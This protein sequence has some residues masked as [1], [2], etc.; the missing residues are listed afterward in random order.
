MISTCAQTRLVGVLLCV[1]ALQRVAALTQLPPSEQTAR[2]TELILQYAKLLAAKQATSAN[3]FLL[4]CCLPVRTLI[5]RVRCLSAAA[6][7]ED[8]SLFLYVVLRVSPLNMVTG[9]PPLG[10][11]SRFCREATACASHRQHEPATC[12][13]GSFVPLKDFARQEPLHPMA[14]WC[15]HR[16][17]SLRWGSDRD[18]Q[19]GHLH[20]QQCSNGRSCLPSERSADGND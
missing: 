6:D 15:W 20:K 1:E 5:C 14:I 12:K 4:S 11:R 7:T 17:S 16:N 10:S 3:S 9:L 13:R 2:L 8:A 18:I 19:V